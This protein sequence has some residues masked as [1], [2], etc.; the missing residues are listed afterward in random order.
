MSFTWFQIASKETQKYIPVN[1][2]EKQNEG[3]NV[4]GNIRSSGNWKHE[5]A[6]QKYSFGT[7]GYLLQVTDIEKI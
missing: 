2:S 6:N 3:M 4:A 7:T 5:S 1:V